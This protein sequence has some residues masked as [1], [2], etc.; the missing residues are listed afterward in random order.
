MT[1]S[2]PTCS[3]APWA[4]LALLAPLALVLTAGAARA[5]TAGEGLYDVRGTDALLGAYTGRLEL[6]TPGPGST[7]PAGGFDVVREVTYQTPPSGQPNG[8][9]L[10]VTSVWLGRAV[11]AGGD[12]RLEF[13][14]ARMGWITEVPGHRRTAAD[15]ARVG[16]TGLLRR[17]A[18]GWAASLA[19]PGHAATDVVT[20][21]GPV[22]TAPLFRP[23]RRLDPIHSPPP[24]WL[25]ALLFFLFRSY[26]GKP[27]VA[28]W[29]RDPRFQ[30]AVHQLLED[31]TGFEWLRARSGQ[32][33]LLVDQVVDPITLAEADARRAAYGLRLHEKAARYDQEAQGRLM[34][35]PGLISSGAR[36]VQG[37]TEKREDMSTFLWSAMWS[38]GQ[39][40][41]YQVTRDPDAL[42]NV[43][44]TTERLCDM[45][46]VDVRPGDFA[47]SLRPLGRAPLG[48]A[49]HAGQ[50]PYAQ[51]AWHDRGNNDMV[52]GVWM[53]FLAAWD[54]LPPTHPLRPRIV[55]CAREITEHFA[56]S[57]GAGSR[58]A[59]SKGNLVLL[60]ML[61]HWMTG[62]ARW[63]QAWRR[64]LRH[65]LT[66]LEFATGGTFAAWGIGDWSGTHLGAC[67]ALGSV[68]LGER[69]GTGW[70]R[71]YR[72]GLENGWRVLRRYR[73]CTALWVVARAGF[74]DPSQASDEA[75]WTLREFPWPKPRWGVDRALDPTW[76]PSP[77]PSLPWKMDWMQG[78]HRLQGLV[79]YPAFMGQPS[80]YVWR[81]GVF[82]P[83]DALDTWEQPGVDY[84]TAYWLGRRLGVFPATE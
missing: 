57:V 21:A 82:D 3:P 4:R 79:S 1:R 38:Y 5:Q 64:A 28:P 55:A 71:V 8:A 84:L 67:T 27:E 48:G 13:S 25:K 60:N 30:A 26:H 77:Y 2:T 69:L 10:P 62:E 81:S 12:L 37:Q 56:T 51:W 58:G 83:G 68:E 63:E 75:T 7:A 35:V 23:M 24:G 42:A 22:A 6:R 20:Y 34:D 50:A 15:Q 52:K 46:E 44:R 66:L 29:A 74:L 76:C 78:T 31:R 14:L 49:W 73:R 61:M 47:R 19:G 33:L 72:M 32:A 11:P 18:A 17:D 80:N 41:R 40:A 16:V 59:R 70:R 9:A 53:G 45:I 36:D 65:P 39:A 54:V 43:E